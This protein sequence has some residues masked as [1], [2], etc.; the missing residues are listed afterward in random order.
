MTRALCLMLSGLS[1]GLRDI[2]QSQPHHGIRQVTRE[3]RSTGTRLVKLAQEKMSLGE[4][5]ELT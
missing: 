5:T 1:A 4:S 2:F 3:S